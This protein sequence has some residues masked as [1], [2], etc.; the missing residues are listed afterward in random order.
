MLNLICGASGTGKTAKLIDCIRRDIEHHTR[1]YLLIP[2]QQ[3]YTS[4]LELP[5]SLPKNAGLYFEV[6]NFSGLADDVFREYG[7]VTGRSVD[8]ALS[9]LLMWDTLRT[10]SPLLRC[11]GRSAK[12]D[13][14]LSALMLG[15]VA[16]L[17]SAGITSEDLERAA[18][19]P[20]LDSRLQDKLSDLALID[21]AYHARLE[22][23]FGQDPA[24]KLQKAA[25]I[26]ASH[27]FFENA[28]IYIDS[29]TSFTSPEYDVI[30]ALLRQAKGV[31]VTLCT[32]SV[33]SHLPHF[34]SVSETAQRLTGIAA[35]V[36]CD[37]KK[38]ILAPIHGQK[39]KELEILDS[40]IWNFS[41]KRESLPVIAPS[42]RGSVR[43]IRCANLYE[44]AEAAALH[45]A[46]LVMSGMRYRDIA[47]VVRDTENYRGVLDA[48]LERHGIPYFLSDR[49]ELSSKP[50]S[51]L[52]LCALRAAAHNYRQSDVLALLKTGLCG[53]ELSDGAMFEEYCETW[54]IS[55]RRFTERLWSMNP[56]GLT[57]DVSPRGKIILEKANLVRAHLIPPLERLGAELRGA[58]TLGEM[59][60]ALYNYLLSIDLP[61][62][63]SDVAGRELQ[64]G[65]K[66]EAAETVRLYSALTDMLSKLC[67][68][69]PD[70]KMNADEF[71]S[72]LNILFSNSDL[73]SIPSLTDCVMIGSAATLRVE[74]I[75]ASLLLGLCEGEFPASVSEDGVFT[76]KDKELLEGLDLNF[77]S[78]RKLR[79]SEELFYVYRALTKPTERLFLST[80]A[81]QTDGSARTPSLAFHRACFLLDL[82]AEEFDTQK[83]AVAEGLEARVLNAAPLTAPPAE[84][85]VTLRLSQTRLKSF[86]LCPYRHYASYI[87]GLREPA[88]STPKYA[89]DGT[90]LHY[91][92]EN[93]LHASLGEDGKLRLPQ[94]HEIEPLADRIIEQY[95]A[96]LFPYSP[97]EDHRLMHLFARLRRLALLML[98]DILEEIGSGLF[99]PTDFERAIGRHEEHSLPPVTLTLKDGSTVLLTGKIDRVDVYEKDGRMYVRVVDYKTGEHLFSTS[100][101]QTG[102]DIQLVLY[103]FAYLSAEPRAEAFGAQYIYIKTEKGASSVRRSGFYLDDEELKNAANPTKNAAYSKGLKKQTAEEIRTLSEDMCR[104]VSEIAER[105]LAGDAQ[106]TPSSEACKFCPIADSCDKAQREE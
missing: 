77:R 9:S 75:R 69:L 36:G 32:D 85:P 87:L 102:M 80:V 31:T 82:Q 12:G 46:E 81:R 2:E 38:Q 45:I 40:N 26:L 86:V 99:V 23:V 34:E 51:R 103:L 13:N 57:G 78:K 39:P 98:R 104:T 33:H 47:V 49:A 55:G 94:E 11:Y 92:F 96:T 73:G 19:S 97:P 83:I 95:I 48:A 100:D 84:S 10:V 22:E 18:S 50:L 70:T 89:D 30:E 90:F 79:N 62:R 88:D 15:T 74:N 63:L 76:D 67:R 8:S 59:C 71:I 29:F 105:M 14:A 56:D 1:C 101:V 28:N 65:R 4:E 54:H 27:A 42:D 5:A 44:E 24:D 61:A 37:T 66:R 35:R 41:V 6:V 64:L 72:A 25:R 16:E 43:C 91:I 93:F 52:I 58:R 68:L 17:R 106:K 53:V 3:A 21:A 20:S 60:H 7:G